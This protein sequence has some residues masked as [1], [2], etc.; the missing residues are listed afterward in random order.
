LPRQISY[1][2]PNGRE[3]IYDFDKLQPNAKLTKESFAPVEIGG[4]KRKM[5]LMGPTVP[6]S[7]APKFTGRE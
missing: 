1:T 7:A 6:P 2:A 4:Y 3:V 5:A